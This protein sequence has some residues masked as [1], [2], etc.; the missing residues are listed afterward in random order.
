MTS[1]PS[2]ASVNVAPL[3]V[4]LASDAAANVNGQVF[5]SY[6]YRYSLLAQPQAVRAIQ[7]DRRWTVEELVELF[8]TTLGARLEP[9]P[10]L[11]FGTVLD[12]RPAEEWR[13]LGNGRRAWQAP[14]EEP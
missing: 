13:D 10:A 5:H 6:G 8:P 9:P 1:T 12:G 7:A 14:G 11:G 2:T 4:Y 3:I